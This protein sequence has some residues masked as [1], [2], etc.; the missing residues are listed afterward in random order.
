M[1]GSVSRINV[2]NAKVQLLQDH[3]LEKLSFL[4]RVVIQ[5][6]YLN[7]NCIFQKSRL[8]K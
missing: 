1:K 7:K 5:V 6:K 2:F 8:N 4:Q 3:L